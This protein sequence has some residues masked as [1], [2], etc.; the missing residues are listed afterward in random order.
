MQIAQNKYSVYLGRV[1]HGRFR[2]LKCIVVEAHTHILAAKAAEIEYPEMKVSRV[3]QRWYPVE[4]CHLCGAP[5]FTGDYQNNQCQHKGQN[6]CLDCRY[7][8]PSRKAIY[9]K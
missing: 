7:T 9:R 4:H 5:I 8:P 1:T 6:K 2:T 3:V